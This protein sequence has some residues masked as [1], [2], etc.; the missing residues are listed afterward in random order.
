MG[1]T[2]P[3][4]PVPDELWWCTLLNQVAASLALGHRSGM[5]GPGPRRPVPSHRLPELA[6]PIGGIGAGS[7][8]MSAFGGFQDFAIRPTP[9]LSALPDGHASTD[10]AFAVL[11][12]RGARP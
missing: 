2:P 11:H 8:S 10:A 3:I 7:I 12:V 1:H 9:R 4:G 6:M 5:P